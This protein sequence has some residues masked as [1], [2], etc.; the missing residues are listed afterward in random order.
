MCSVATN[1]VMSLEIRCA[2]TLCHFGRTRKA[3]VAMHFIL[4]ISTTESSATS[5]Y[6][7]VPQRFVQNE[8]PAGSNKEQARKKPSFVP[9]LDLIDALIF[10]SM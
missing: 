1:L 3:Y 2:A 9:K 7:V 10:L 6:L 4:L 5:D 8:E